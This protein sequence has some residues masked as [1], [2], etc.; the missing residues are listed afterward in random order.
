[1]LFYFSGTGNSLYLAQKI[2]EQEDT[3]LVS[4]HDAVLE[5]E[6]TYDADEIVGF[7]FPSYFYGLP[8]TVKDFIEKLE[9]KHAENAYVFSAVTCGSVT[10]G[11]TDMLR[12]C[13]ASCGI[14]LNAA[15][16]LRTVDN[17]VP[18]LM[19]P[20]PAG[21]SEVLAIA[22]IDQ[23]Q[24]LLQIKNRETG[25]FDTLKGKFPELKTKVAYPVYE[26]VRNTKN[27]RVNDTLCIGCGLC[28]KAC[29]SNA[30]EMRNKRPV[31]VVDR[32]NL[33]LKCL[34]RCRKEAIEFGKHTNQHGR[35][36]NP[37]ADWKWTSG[38]KPKLG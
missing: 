18:G 16:V 6:Y 10:G 34:H 8:S 30:I 29:N 38:K 25:D 36:E 5:S 21:I 28:A 9:L 17:F 22:E 7:I 14:P 11:T 2:A 26:K 32:C 37:K 27:F 35:Y 12:S 1:M 3:A 24:I 20:S 33:C 13:L 31:W 4:I 15:Y 19:M 23:E